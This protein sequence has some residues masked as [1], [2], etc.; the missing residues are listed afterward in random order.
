MEFVQMVEAA[1]S[2]VD[3]WVNLVTGAG[4]RRK[5]KA[6]QF[7]PDAVLSQDL[8]EQ[9][10]TSDPYANRICRIVPEE[11][12]RQGATVQT[13]V[14]G[15]DDDVAEYLDGFEVNARLVRGWTWG[16]VFGGG[17]IVIGAD[18]GLDPSEPLDEEGIRSVRF[19]DVVDAR[20]LQPHEYQTDKLAKN[21]GEPE[22][23]RLQRSGAGGASDYGVWHRSRLVLFDGAPTTRRRRQILKGWGESELQRIYDVLSKFNGG[24]ES[25]ST[26]MQVSSE[27]VLKLKNLMNMLG[28]DKEG[29]IKKRFEMMDLARGVTNSVLLD[30]DGEDYTRTE[31]G[32]LA[33]VAAVLSANMLN[34]SGAAEIPVI[35]LMGQSPAGFSSGDGDM[36]WFYDRVKS[37]QTQV[38]LPRHRRLVRILLAA[39]D[40]PTKGKLPP[41][42]TIKYAPLWQL[43]PL[44]EAQRRLAVAQADQVNITAQMVTADEAAASRFRADGWNAE[45]VINL[46]DREAA[47]QADRDAANATG[48]QGADAPGGDHAEAV[49]GVLAK[50]A[51]REIPRDAGVALLV[52]SMGM[53][54][55]DAES[56]MGETGRTFFTAPAPNDGAELDQLRA[57]NAKLKASNQGHK[58]YTSRVVAAAK[59]G[60][61]QLGKFTAAAPTETDEGD[62]LEA[63][64]VVA[65]PVP[66]GPGAGR[67][68][69]GP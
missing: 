31:V 23:Y 28:G 24:W 2:R 4:D 9:L 69:P 54:L 33:G 56:V 11:A 46:A 47:M 5:S 43:D 6:L 14:A 44:Q 10:Y 25:S 53:E 66:V 64:D 13:G 58:A 67:P 26:L 30:S 49:S 57:E 45:T 60:S 12:L 18:D 63:G 38:L 1:L 29:L 16:R 42:L 15:I 52:Q 51:G 3:G 41:R 65:V 55:L 36:R 37:T 22:T 8:L 48:G 27:G 21:F 20:E 62:V 19:L 61:L 32:A 59:D 40:S 50:V 68:P 17:G 34:L 35:V 39:K 7:T